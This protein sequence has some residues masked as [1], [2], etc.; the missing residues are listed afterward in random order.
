MKHLIF[1]ILIFLLSFFSPCSIFAQ[2]GNL[3]P[4]PSFE[5]YKKLPD[6]LSQA[7]KCISSWE[8]P[9]MKGS[10]EYYHSDCTSKKVRTPKNYF[11]KQIPH[12]GKAYMGLCVTKNYREYLQV[13]LN[14]SL[15]KDREYRILIYISCADK[16]WLG[17]INEFN[18]LFS[19]ESFL[20]PANENLLELPKVKFTGEF[21]NKKKWIELSTTYTADGTERFITFGSFAYIENGTTHGEI[22]GIAKYAHYYVDDASITLIDAEIPLTQESILEEA[23]LTDSLVNYELG[24]T[25]RFENLLFE[26][27]ESVLLP[28][29][30]PEIGKLI[31]F[32]EKR[33]EY[34]L[35]ITGHTDSQGDSELNMKLSLDRANALKHYLMD[36]GIKEDLITI[37]GKGD[38]FPLTSNETEEGRK[39]NRRVEIS[40][41]K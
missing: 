40:I 15:I 1:T 19:Q 39:R 6:D 25:Y 11:G 41:I 20:I 24:E 3:I 13:K 22:N 10:A 29:E 35:F 32:L 2:S 7:P 12:S 14:Q 26:S 9:N 21:K 28:N 31:Q 23:P 36:K 8:I 18:V 34:K 30:Y 27:G 5:Y 16:F 17:T 37:E 33:S 4:N 38:K